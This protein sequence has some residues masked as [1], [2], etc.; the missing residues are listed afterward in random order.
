MRTFGVILMLLLVASC[1]DTTEGAGTG[2]SGGTAGDSGSGGQA[3]T[4]GAGGSAGDGGDSGV[5]GGAGARGERVIF[6]TDTLQDAALGGFDG[7]DA[8]CAAQASAA[9]LSGEFKVWLS[10]L[11]TAA[12]DR[13]TR[14]DVPYVLVD[15]TVVAD[16]WDDLTDGA[17]QTEIDLDANG[18]SRGGDVWT[19]TLPSG[20]AF[21]GNDC[22]GF[23][24]NESG[25]GL[26]GTTTSA[27]SNWTENAQPSCSTQLRLYC[28][29]Q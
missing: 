5:G 23:T 25:I 22:G 10:T 24:T 2:G 20:L 19:G 14:S 12:A 1:S 4:G 13:L 26:C 9:E 6:V 11:D 29:E 7:A 28:I 21:A 3:G 16:D 8:I 27:S 18:V 17:I 15:G